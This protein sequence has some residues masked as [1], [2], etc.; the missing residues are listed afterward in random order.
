[1]HY[2]LLIPLLLMGCEVPTD[3]NG[4]MKLRTLGGGASSVAY[5]VRKSGKKYALKRAKK[6]GDILKREFDILKKFSGREGFPEVYDFFKC[7]DGTDCYTMELVGPVI[8]DIQKNRLSGSRELPVETVGT[9]A[10]QMVDRMEEMHAMGYVHGDLFRNNIAPGIGRKSKILFAIDFGQVTS[11]S[12]PKPRGKDF[13]IRSFAFSVFGML[14]K[15]TKYGDYQHYSEDKD[16][17]TISNLVKGLP[18]EVLA[19]MKYANGLSSD[20]KIDYNMLKEL[21]VKMV[22]KTGNKFKGEIIWPPEVLE[23]LP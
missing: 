18:K 12:D 7:P 17:P 20:D 3:F 14:K 2:C 10:I 19:V 15:G 5:E 6:R 8:G 22:E 21:M 4:F 13:D 11:S 1:M 9:I 16:R 23:K